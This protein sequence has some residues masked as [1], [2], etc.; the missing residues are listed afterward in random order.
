MSKHAILMNYRLLLSLVGIVLSFSLFGQNPANKWTADYSKSK[1]FI[2]NKGQFD[3]EQTN[4]TGEIKFAVDF[5]STRIFFGENGIAYSFLEAK[6]IPKEERERLTQQQ[7]NSVQDHKRYEKLVGKFNFKRDQVTIRWENRSAAVKLIG[8]NQTSDYHNYSISDGNGG[9]K[10]ISDAKGYEKIVYENVYE[11][12][13]VEYTVHPEI[14]IKYALILHPGADPSMVKMAFDRSVELIDGKLSIATDFGPILDHAP[15]TFY[16]GDQNQLIDSRFKLQNQT[17]SFELGNYDKSR[18][19]VIDPW[20]QTPTF[21]TNWDVVWECERDAAGN[22]YILGGIMPMQILKYNATG[23]LQWTYNTPY[24][25][26]NVWLG[27]FAVDNLGNSY[28][29]AGSVAQIQKISPAGALLV[30]NA[31]PGGI[32]SSAEFWTISFNCDQT[33]LIIGGTGGSILQLDAVIYNVNTSNLNITNEQFISNGPMFAIPPNLEEVRAITSAPNGKYYIMTHDTIGYMNDNFNLCPNNSTSLFKTNHGAGWGYKCENFRY[34]NTGMSAITADETAVYLHRGNQLQKRS[35]QTG[36]VLQTVAIPNGG[37]NNVFLGGNQATNSGIAVDDC[38]N[39]YVGST[40][41]VYKFSSTLTQLAVYPT[42]FKVFDVEVNSGGEIIACGGTGTSTDATRSGGVA[43]IAAT[44]C[45]PLASTC[46]DASICIPQGV[47]ASDA[48]FTLTT[49]T[50]GG[51][52]SGPGVSATGVFSPTVAGIG[53]HTI[54]YTLA[55]GSESITITVSSCQNLQVCVE[56][57]GNLSVTGGVGPYTWQQFIPAQTTP[58][59]TQAQCQAC[60]YTWLF[61]TCVNGVIPATSCSTPASWA[62]FGTGTSVTPPVGATQLQV[63]DGTGAITPI[64]PL[65]L[66]AC[67]STACSPNGNLIIYSNYDGGILTINVDQNIPNLKV[68]ICTYEPIQ[69]AFTGPFV[70]N[71]TQVIYA[72]FNSN[73]NNNNCGQGNF[74]T[75]ITGVPAGIVTI[76][77]P[78]NP[79]QVGF[80]PAH[81]NGSGPWGGGMLGVAGLCDTTINAG[82]GNTPDEVV[83]YFTNATGGTLLFHQTQYNCWLNETV[84]ITAG[85]NCCILPSTSPNNPCPNIAV[86]S[87]N[88]TNVN[89][90]GQSTGAATVNASGGLAPYTYSWVPGNLTGATQTGLAAGTYTVNVLDANNC[91]GTATV[92]ITQPASALAVTTSSTNS[93]CG[94]STGSAT[95]SVNGGSIPYTYSWSP[96]GGTNNTANNLS[97]GI[98]TVTV[99]D[100]NGCTTSGNVTVANSNGPSLSLVSSNDASCFGLSDGSAVVSGSGGTGVLTYNWTPGN[101]TGASQNALVAGTYTVQVTDNANCTAVVSVTINS[102]SQINVTESIVNINCSPQTT[103]SISTTV[104]GGVGPYNYAWNPG[105]STSPGLTNIAAGNYSLTV[106]DANGCTTNENYTVTTTGSIPIDIVPTSAFITQGDSVQLTVTGSAITWSWTPPTGL[107]CTDCEN[108][109]ASPQT[110]TI[111]TVTGTDFEGCSG[112]AE[113]TIVVDPICGDVFVPTVFTPDGNGY[114]ANNMICVYGNCIVSFNY[115]VFN[116]WGEKVFESSDQ[117]TCWDGKYKDKPLNSGVFAYKFS[118]LLQNGQSIEQSGN[119]TLIR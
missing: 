49:A 51:T 29:T 87:S 48:P 58:I 110:T 100:A 88:V 102:P 17:V 114:T 40:N 84:N 43:V 91:P 20:T 62:T 112:T 78:M 94:S 5:G 57:N 8:L 83:Y 56:A 47:C 39:V 118:A 95:A 69:V 42:A 24:D 108:P 105:G 55:C 19:L 63:I 14:G 21:A 53:V 80:T 104:T 2:E 103:G 67:G 66:Q 98:Y 30:N 101:L 76:N 38:G 119:L 79:P 45:V 3:Q 115:V 13:D 73:Q 27:T 99:T 77:P 44:A 50:A 65:T 34:D 89:C 11:N 117:S 71:I 85:G 86:N 35:L 116:R 32:I 82:G 12:I 75:S 60:G 10:A 93:V 109:I 113:I 23:A 54:T 1:S 111:Y 92:T 61:G 37:F 81:G 41:G 106:T 72:G 107:S 90:F 26:S 70:G 31:S 22:V 7:R 9:R 36:A 52:W 16:E 15:I 97:A 4:E 25:T 68:G 18:T 74:T 59:S 28:V 6:K 46:C 96:S 64:N 33:A